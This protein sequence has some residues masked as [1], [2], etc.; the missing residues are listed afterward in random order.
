VVGAYPSWRGGDKGRVGKRLLTTWATRVY[1]GGAG[2]NQRFCSALGLVDLF[3]SVP[4]LRRGCGCFTLFENGQVLSRAWI[5]R[6]GLWYSDRLTKPPR[7]TRLDVKILAS[8]VVMFIRPWS[9]YRWC[10]RACSH[11]FFTNFSKQEVPMFVYPKS[12]ASA[13][14]AWAGLVRLLL[15]FT[16]PHRKSKTHF[17]TFATMAPTIISICITT[18]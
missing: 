14:S 12:V 5:F 3:R 9:L 1:F 7:P 16:P 17:R 10:V 15:R 6:L 8:S 13:K 18:T 4:A 2:C 11:V